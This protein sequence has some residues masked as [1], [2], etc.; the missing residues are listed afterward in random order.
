MMFLLNPKKHKKQ[1]KVIHQKILKNPMN[2][3][4]ES[5]MEKAAKK[6]GL[7]Y[8]RGETKVVVELKQDSENVMDEIKEIG[9]VDTKSDKHVQ[10]T[11]RVDEI[12]KLVKKIH[13]L[14]N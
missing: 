3:P 12:P 8:K 1:S 13:Q 11:V 9:K 2:L 7:Q 4:D 10:V 6:L 14:K 5:A